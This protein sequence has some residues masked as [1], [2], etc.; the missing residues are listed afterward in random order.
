MDGDENDLLS[1]NIF[2]P[3]PELKDE[4]TTESNEEFKKYYKNEINKLSEGKMKE[5]FEKMSLK[6]IQLDEDTDSNSIF[7]TNQFRTDNLSSNLINATIP[8]VKRYKKDIITYVSIDSRDRD[9]LIY[10]KANH[11]KIFLGKTFYNVK[12]VKLIRIEFP[13]TDAVINSSNNRIYWRNLEDIENDIFD[14]VTKTY[15]IYQANMRIGRL[16]SDIYSK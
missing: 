10:S 2:I 13:N 4:V 12:S 15:R 1:T 6:S 5:I 9:K 3:Q 14:T 16:Y 11:F 7:N 8:E